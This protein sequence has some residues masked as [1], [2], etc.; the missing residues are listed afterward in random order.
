[1]WNHSVDEDFIKS[2]IWIKSWFWKGSS[3]ISFLESYLSA[4]QDRRFTYD[5]V[6]RA[7]FPA[8]SPCLFKIKENEGAIPVHLH[9]HENIPWQ[10]LP[11][12]S[13]SGRHK[14]QRLAERHVG[15]STEE[16]TNFI[17]SWAETQSFSVPA[18]FLSR[19]HDS[20]NTRIIL[21]HARMMITMYELA[22]ES[23][24][25]ASRLRSSCSFVRSL[26]R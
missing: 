26:R 20:K 24:Q 6:L 19:V 25:K 21:I 23:M 10:L 2:R 17:P 13:D 14:K 18:N 9:T 11:E 3:I 4:S 15:I 1:M 12:M 7:T 5:A 22:D 8:I 16:D